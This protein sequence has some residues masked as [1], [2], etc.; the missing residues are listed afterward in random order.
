MAEIT[1]MNGNSLKGKTL[2]TLEYEHESGRMSIGGPLENLDRVLNMLSQAMRY[3]ESQYRL[4]Q[5]AQ[6]KAQAEQMHSVLGNIKPRL[7]T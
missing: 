2:I 7:I 1:D 4:G 5:A 3:L 6:A